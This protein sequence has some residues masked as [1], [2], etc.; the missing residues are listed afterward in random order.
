MRELEQKGSLTAHGRTVRLEDVSWMQKGDTFAYVSDTRACKETLKV[1][2]DAKLFL[3][4][5]TYLERDRDLAYEHHHLTARGAAEIARDAGASEL[6]L[7]HFSARY[8]NLDEFLQEARPVFPHT[9]V[10][11]DLKIIPFPRAPVSPT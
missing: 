2:R 8:Q 5:S 10:A 9:H 6:V 4:E 3:C 11:E 1:A 7:T